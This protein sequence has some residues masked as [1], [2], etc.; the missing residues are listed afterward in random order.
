[1]ADANLLDVI[2]RRGKR[3][4]L[5][6]IVIF[7]RIRCAIKEP[8][9]LSGLKVRGGMYAIIDAF[10]LKCLGENYFAENG[11]SDV[12][13]IY[14]TKGSMIICI[15]NLD[16]VG[17]TVKV[18]GSSTKRGVKIK[19]QFETSSPRDGIIAIQFMYSNG[20]YYVS[21]NSIVELG[22]VDKDVRGTV[23][24]DFMASIVSRECKYPATLD[25]IVSYNGVSE[26]EEI[27]KEDIKELNNVSTFVSDN[28]EKIDV[29]KIDLHLTYHMNGAEI[30]DL[31]EDFKEE[32]EVMSKRR[33]NYAKELTNYIKDCYDNECSCDCDYNAMGIDF[34]VPTTVEV[35]RDIRTRF[36]SN[37]AGRYNEVIGQSKFRGSYY[38]NLITNEILEGN[39]CPLADKSKRKLTKDLVSRLTDI[40]QLDNSVLYGT[41]EFSDLDL[42]RSDICFSVVVLGICCGIEIESLAYNKNWCDRVY[43][44]D[45]NLWFYTLIRYPYLLGMIGP[46]LS[47]LDC[48][49]IY[50]SF[51]KYY[52]KGIINENNMNTRCSMLFLESVENAS[53]KDSMIEEGILESMKSEYPKK[54]SK[55][56]DTYGLPVNL[57][58]AEVL[59]VLLGA[60]IV[61]NKNQVKLIKNIKWYSRE[62]RD[63]LINNGLCN[64]VDTSL[65]L[66]NDL[67]K[68][69]L[70][71]NILYY[72]G[73]EHTGLTDDQIKETISEFEST[74]GFKLEKLQ[75]DGIY[76]TKFKAAVLSG[77][78]GSGKTTTSDCM[79]EALKKLGNF[80][81]KYELVYCTPTGKACRRLAEVV[82]CS[83]KTIHSQFGIGL[84]GGTYMS[85][86]GSRYKVQDKIKIYLMDEMAMCDMNLLYE[87]C[88]NLGPDDII[89]FLGDIKQLSPIGRG[90]PFA[91][92]MKLLPCVELGVSKRAAEGSLVNYNTTL[93]NC[94]SDG[95]V[96]ELMYNDKDFF[97]V[98]CAD[99]TIPMVIASVW[100]KFMNGDMNGI[101]YIED[102]IQVITGYQKDD[103]IFSAP[104]LNV[105]IQKLLRSKDK[106]L[107]MHGNR[108]FYLNDRVIHVKLNSY[109][110]NRYVPEGSNTFRSVATF[111][112][113][114][115][116]IGKLVSIVR[117][118]M[119][120]IVDFKEDSCIAGKD[121]YSNVS[122]EE[123]KE[124]ISKRKESELDLRDDSSVKNNRQYFVIVKVY[125]VE[126]QKDV[127]VL[128]T[129]TS[130][131]KD[132]ILI[133]EG[134]DLDCLDLAYALTTYKMQ[135]SQSKVVINAFGAKCS[136]KFINRNMIN[137]MFTRSQGI[138]CN[139]GSVLGPESTINIGRKYVSNVNCNDALSILVG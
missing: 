21:P 20:E 122:E 94:L 67:E 8:S 38:V 87:I 128:Y 123:L 4:A 14:F 78:A 22:V 126:L 12:N 70:I 112:I 19:Q 125:D 110:M 62:K 89:Y 13:R 119:V 138:V 72:K 35:S 29:T 98:D 129:A 80:D 104:R 23:L 30:S 68:E 56:L 93:V 34:S 114:N 18:Y 116:E 58:K 44:M 102:D 36:I 105:V 66:E 90:T 96:R 130:R 108:E 48:D 52:G 5:E 1:M 41:G 50:F 111:G 109:S 101:K 113:V 133:L 136:P 121:V 59:K 3:N 82:K 40:V 6:N 71:Y 26:Y 118:D 46:C 92:L 60:D 43:G 37:I 64:L 77:C 134:S 117:S 17:K 61:L 95:L 73:H 83:V 99:V 42:L 132:G 47:L 53:S 91:L 107:F 124:L 25:S 74:K 33:Y 15:D 7:G 32:I 75:K 69:F 65:I 28:N 27:G 54:G 86:V 24:E 135:G 55:Y 57:D 81:E 45:L 31:Y 49:K 97:C 103:I 39:I 88:R 11:Y 115:G 137:T 2:R 16:L 9:I 106:L 127:V 76:L 63:E 120:N 10:A 84:G 139:V 100:K 85:S 51:S 79:T 131:M